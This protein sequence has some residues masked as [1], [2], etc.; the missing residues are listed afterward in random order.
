MADVAAR[1]L[2]VVVVLSLVLREAAQYAVWP[3]CRRGRPPGG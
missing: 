3:T 2:E 1:N